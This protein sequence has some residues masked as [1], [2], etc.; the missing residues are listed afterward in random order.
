MDAHAPELLTEAI[1]F[2]DLTNPKAEFIRHNENMTYSIEDGQMKYLLRIHQ[3]AEGLDFSTSRGNL[4][5]ESLISSE[6]HLL[7]CLSSSSNLIVQKPVKNRDNQYITRLTNGT[8]ATVLSWINGDT[9]YRKELSEPIV[10]RIGQMVG[11]LHQSTRALPRLN[12]CV[13]DD[14]VADVLLSETQ[15]AKEIGRAHV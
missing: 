7:N 6:I 10:Y 5:G 3:E 15:V 14:S 4:S 8:I 9:L 11:A 1:D 2:Y 12:R 13:Y